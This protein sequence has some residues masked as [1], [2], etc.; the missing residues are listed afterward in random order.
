MR[1]TGMNAPLG[2]SPCGNVGDFVRL[3]LAATPPVEPMPKAMPP[4]GKPIWPATLASPMPAHQGCSP[5]TCRCRL[6]LMVMNMRLPGML[7]AS[8]L[9]RAASM[10]VISAAHSAVFGMPSLSPRR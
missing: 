7:A 6:Q 2:F 9:M 8:A 10:P 3:V 1:A 5:W 4:P